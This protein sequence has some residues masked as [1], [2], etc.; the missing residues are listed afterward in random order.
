MKR[1]A[2]LAALAVCGIWVWGADGVYFDDSYCPE[3]PPYYPYGRDPNRWWEVAKEE[4]LCP[5]PEPTESPDP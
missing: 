2:L 4:I 3:E 5:A 1:R